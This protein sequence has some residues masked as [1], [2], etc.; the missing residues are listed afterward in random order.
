M[1]KVNSPIFLFEKRCVIN[2][3]HGLCVRSCCWLAKE[4]SRVCGP[5]GFGKIFLR[6][7]DDDY[8]VDIFSISRLMTLI[9]PVKKEMIVL[10]NEPSLCDKVEHL[11]S[12]I[13]RFSLQKMPDFTDQEFSDILKKVKLGL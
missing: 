5:A 8:R 2:E 3:V 7:A 1:E 9:V 13:S 11:A 4:A 6:R 10:A 12:F